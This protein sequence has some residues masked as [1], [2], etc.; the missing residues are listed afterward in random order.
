MG[1][2]VE[3]PRRRFISLHKIRWF[4]QK[5]VATGDLDLFDKK[6]FFEISGLLLLPP[7]KGALLSLRRWDF[8]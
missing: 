4:T 1:L 7:P 8:A 3:P 5:Q 6:L 2:R